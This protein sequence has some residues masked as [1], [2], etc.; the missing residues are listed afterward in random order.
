MSSIDLN[1][2]VGEGVNN[3]AALMPL[4]SSCN[5]ACGGHAGSVEIMKEVTALAIKNNVKIGAHPGYC[6]LYT[7]PSPRDS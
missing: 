3:E 1:S 6:L 4:I 7:S 5:I 2:D